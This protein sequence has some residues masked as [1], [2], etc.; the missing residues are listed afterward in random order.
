MSI[1]FK[2]SNV[3]FITGEKS[4]SSYSNSYRGEWLEVFSSGY[5]G[6]LKLT[7][8]WQGS[9]YMVKHKHPKNSVY[10]KVLKGE[11][12]YMIESEKYKA[13]EGE[14]ICIPPN[15]WHTDPFN[16]GWQPCIL[17]VYEIEQDYIEY[18]KYFFKCVEEEKYIYNKNGLPTNKQLKQLEMKYS[19]VIC[20]KKFDLLS[21]FQV[22]INRF[23][24]FLKRK[25]SKK[26]NMNKTQN[27]YKKKRS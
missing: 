6:Y 3:N 21:K 1:D 8:F 7:L 9:G 17:A 2:Y 26:L 18:F 10:Y 5:S 12:S 22:T 4:T 19:N 15:T 24:F 14:T 20:F 16:T 27:N 23:A 11:A 13:R 25:C